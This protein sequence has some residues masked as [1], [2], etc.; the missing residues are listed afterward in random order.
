MGHNEVVIRLEFDEISF[1][2]SE[3]AVKEA[4]YEYLTELIENDDLDYE[5]RL[6]RKQ[7]LT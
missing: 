5:V 3:D 2:D 1:E 7:C 4:V 6:R